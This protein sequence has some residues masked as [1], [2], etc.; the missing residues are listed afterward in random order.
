[1]SVVVALDQ[2]LDRQAHP[3]LGEAAHFEQAG[4]ELFEL[5]LEMRERRCSQ[6][7]AV[8]HLAES[9]GDVV[10]GQLLRRMR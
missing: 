3:L 6:S 5:L 2:A 8:S 10:L 9:P 1:M 7:L 4:L